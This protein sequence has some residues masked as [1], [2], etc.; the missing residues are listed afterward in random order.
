MILHACKT[1]ITLYIYVINCA[2][3]ER[4]RVELEILDEVI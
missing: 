2:Q 4:E 3:R 1:H